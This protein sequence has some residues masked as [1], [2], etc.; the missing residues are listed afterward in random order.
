MHKGRTT[1]IGINEAREVYRAVATEASLLYFVMLQLCSVDHMYQFSL[2]SFTIYFLKALKMAAAT[3]VKTQR[4]QNLQSTLRWVVFKWVVRGLFE[5]HRLIFLT[6]LTLSLMQHNIIGEESGFTQE[7]LKF[8]L[9]GPRATADTQS[10]VSWIS[11]LMWGGI[12]NLSALDGFGRFANDVEDNA[13]RFLEWYQHFNPESEKLPLDWRELDKTPFK[14][15][16]VVRVLRPDRI[17]AALTGFIRDMIPKGRQFIE[18]DSQLNSLQVLEQSFEDSSPLTP[19]YFILSPGADI[20]SDV[21]KLAVK[22]GKVKGV[23]YHNISL[24]QG[25]DVVAHEKL[26]IGH[27]Q[28]HWIVLNNVHLM[29]K[30]L[31][32]LEKKLEYY[33]ETGTHEDF[34][35]LLSSDP[36]ASIPVSLLERSIKLTS[37][38]PSGLK[39]NLKQAFACFAN[40]TYDELEP[41][42][43]GILFGL[44]QFHAVLVE[45]KKFGAKG[46]NMMYPFSI[47]DLVCS[48]AVLRNYME[49]APAKVPWADLRYLFGE[50]MYGGHIVNDFDRLLAKTYLEFYMKEELLDEMPLYPFL[51]RDMV[52]V[53]RSP[54]TGASYV[55]VVDHIDDSLKSETPLAFGLHPNAE[56]GFRTQMSEDLLK[57][58]LELSSADE[59]SGGDGQNSQMVAEVILQDILEMFRDTN[60]DLEGMAQGMEEVGPFQHVVLQECERMNMLLGEIVRSL[61]ELDL[62]FRGDLTMS[63]GMEDLA[64]SLFL[65]RVPKSWE[66]LAYPSMR[67]LSSWLSDLQNRIAQVTEWSTNPTETPVVTWISGLFNPQSF[68]TAVM[69]STAQSHGQELDKLTLITDL[70]KKLMAEEITT[71]AKDGAYITGLS[72]EGAAWNL[73]SSIMEPSKPREMFSPLPV[74]NIRPCIIDRFEN[75]IYH[76]PVYKTQQRGPT[77]VFSVQLRTKNDPAKW[78]LAGVVAV[79]DVI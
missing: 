10:P 53:F 57:T 35:V 74:M 4:V 30:W 11:D 69:Q 55:K 75:G 31:S 9:L 42:S 64:Q 43:K 1:E 39:A 18:C 16:L 52:D 5:K 25:Q 38:P 26:E 60:F 72:L 34:R 33:A 78:I 29:P 62:G 65:D 22:C 19:L 76:C 68:I 59:V 41:R 36:S 73:T 66:T 44:C 13:P 56:I 54:S 50:I 3:S 24:G 79:M 27:R 17:T 15:L 67:T 45:R 21:D 2:D 7:G 70:T 8:L 28:G 32:V 51:D 6:Q 63:D 37:D 23:D 77:Y 46:Y 20:V 12:K 58:I 47:G 61:V 71:P 40:D 14:K 48:V 49:S